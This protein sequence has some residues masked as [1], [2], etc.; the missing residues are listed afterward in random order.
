LVVI[1][2]ILM[3]SAVALP[4]LASS[5]SRRQMSEAARILQGA[6]VGARDKAIHAGQP[7]GIRLLPDPAFPIAWTSGGTIDPYS[8]LAYSRVIPIDPVPPYSEG[9]CIAVPP[10]ALAWGPIYAPY[11]IT[12]QVSFTWTTAPIFPQ[13]LFLV[14]SPVDPATGQPNA[15]TTWFWNIRVGDRIQLNEA[16]PWYTI[17]GPLSVGP[18]QGNTEMFVNVGPTGPLSRM[19]VPAVNGQPVEYLILVNSFDDNNNGW[20]DEGFDG[21]DNNANG[22]FDEYMEWE[23]ERWSP[24]VSSQTSVNI[25]YLVRRRPGPG[26]GAREEALPTAVVIDATTGLLTQE[27]SRLPVNPY[28][29]CVDLVLNPDGTVLPN[30]VYSSP[31]SFGMKD[32]FY[33]FWLA[34]RADLLSAKVST[35]TPQP[36]LLPICGPGGANAGEYTGRRIQGSYSLL[37]LFTRTGEIVVN[38]AMPFDNPIAAASAKRPYNVNMPFTGSQVGA[39]GS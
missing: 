29:G 14:A 20:I 9:R 6:L 5:V 24:V 2:I 36:P 12:P 37:T 16:G 1:L 13:G 38:E 8:I 34:E 17:I 23:T 25:P 19:P 15:P 22:L 28:S 7:S 21:I 18:A 30:L 39:T 27:R 3:A 4:L 10:Q 32:A 33:H 35:G 11:A 26:P 31:S